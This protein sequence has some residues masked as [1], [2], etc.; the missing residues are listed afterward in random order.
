MDRRR[1][2]TSWRSVSGNNWWALFFSP[3]YCSQGGWGMNH[4][5]KNICGAN[6]LIATRFSNSS[7]LRASLTSGDQS[8]P[9]KGSIDELAEV[10][11]ERVGVAASG[12][13]ET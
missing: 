9:V 11:L 6:A 13:Q 7:K 3:S 1:L 4:R 12:D 8:K 10:L 2:A 5:S